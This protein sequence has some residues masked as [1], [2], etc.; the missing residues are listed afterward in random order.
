MIPPAS[1]DGGG[2]ATQAAQ[3]A[4]TGKA[5]QPDYGP[6]F[7]GGAP[8]AKSSPKPTT[9][10]ESEV[11]GGGFDSVPS[12]EE[13]ERGG[14]HSYQQQLQEVLGA[15]KPGPVATTTKTGAHAEVTGHK[16]KAA[17]GGGAGAPSMEDYYREEE[18]RSPE[19]QEPELGGVSPGD[20][21]EELDESKRIMEMEESFKKDLENQKWDSIVKNASNSA[22]RTAAVHTLQ[23][24][25]KLKALTHQ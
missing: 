1:E 9:S 21:T 10:D 8:A 11:G 20:I 6:L 18:Q 5:T 13:V 16:G 4:D 7:G 2:E 14:G 25:Q 15:G 12:K 19:P 17:G 23:E 3:A 24:E 22:Y